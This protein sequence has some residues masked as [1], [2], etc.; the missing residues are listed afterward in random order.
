MR[1][2]TLVTALAVAG[3]LAVPQSASATPPD[4]T[5]C[6]PV[7]E[8]VAT[9]AQPAGLVDVA[10]LAV[11]SAQVVCTHDPLN[12]TVNEMTRLWGHIS[13]SIQVD[14][15]TPPGCAT[16]PLEI[17][18]VGPVLVLATVQTCLIPVT[19]PLRLGTVSMV[20]HW[21]TLEKNLLTVTA[22][23]CCDSRRVFA[24]PVGLSIG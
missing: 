21:A 9:P 23:D 1:L 16:G 13:V 18:A 11:G 7:L 17:P 20:V 4:P 22:Y 10:V 24:T 8:L 3:G 14:G 19:D 6:T 15:T 2:R 5:T 12:S